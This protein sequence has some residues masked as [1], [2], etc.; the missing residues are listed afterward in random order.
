[1]AVSNPAIATDLYGE[2]Y[3][4]W[5]DGTAVLFSTDLRSTPITAFSQAVAD[6]PIDV[7]IDANARIRVTYLDASGNR[8]T[9][10]SRRDGD[11]GTWS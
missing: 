11:S 5:T 2:Q 3:T 1:M 6:N 8:L 10:S 9:K 4:F 7:V